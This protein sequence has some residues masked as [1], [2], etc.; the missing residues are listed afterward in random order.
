M[1]ATIRI[2]HVVAHAN[3]LVATG[4]GRSAAATFWKKIGKTAAM[5][6]V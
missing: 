3:R 1:T 5:I 2:D 4:P 6:V